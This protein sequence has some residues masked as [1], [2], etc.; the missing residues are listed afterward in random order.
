MEKYYR[1]I[2]Y[3]PYCG[4]E[5]TGYC[6]I[7]DGDED[8]LH[9]FANVLIAE[10]ANEHIHDHVE[11]LTNEEE[12]EEFYEGCGVRLQEI[13]YDTYMEEAFEDYELE[14]WN[15]QNEGV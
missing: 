2:A 5:F 3:T 11:D 1:V 13:S 4:E 9:G 7:K 6:A 12:C 10:N 15:E 14:D 8:R